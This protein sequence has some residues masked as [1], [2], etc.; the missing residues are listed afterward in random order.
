MSHAG[1]TTNRPFRVFNIIN[2]KTEKKYKLFL[3]ARRSSDESSDKQAQSIEDQ[4]SDLR[5]VAERQGIKIVEIL[6]ESKSSKR[7]Y[8]RPVFQSMLER[9]EAGEADGILCWHINRLSR[10]PIDSGQISWML[11]KGTI[12][13]IQT[14]ER[15]Y[16]PEDNVLLFSVESGMANQYIR[17]LAVASRRGMQG[18]ADRGWLP[19][20]A[21]LGY[22]N[23]LNNQIIIP[24]SERWDMVRKM[25]DL[26]LTGNYTVTQIQQIANNEWGFRTPKF[27]RSG[28]KVV[29]LSSLYR[30]FTNE[31]YTGTFV[32][33]GRQYSG[34]HE[35]MITNDEYDKVQVILGRNG[36]P[37]QQVH[38]SSY[39]GLVRC[40]EC[41]S[42]CTCTL[43]KKIVKKTGKL[44]T[45]VYYNCSK[46]KRDKYT[47]KAICSQKPITLK[48][49]EEQVDLDLERY[50]IIPKFQEWAL[51]VINRH[52]DTEIKERTAIYETQ[53][54][55]YN[56]T[57][58]QL[59]ML[60][61]MRYRLLIEEDEFLKERDDLKK[62][63]AKLKEKLETT[64]DRAKK[65]LELTEQTFNFAR[66]ARKEY[67]KGDIQKKRELFAAL[68]QNYVLKDKIVSIE[69]SEW[70]MPIEKAYP[71]L[72]A[73]FNR[74]ELDK[75]LSKSTYNEE[76]ASLILTWGGYRESNPGLKLHKLQ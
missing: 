26:I 5:P 57:Q 64:E 12:K 9:I 4:I 16:L 39:T 56:E 52:N 73:E 63:L 7:P 23:D 71:A 32:W 22:R 27:K 18:K 1:S 58:T 13:V 29:G 17:D 35:P 68:G 25:W 74:L 15:E 42:M 43:K 61:R 70:L 38:D 49:F 67:I 62:Q 41:G 51:D 20:R 3:Y 31:F 55:T 53:Q 54:K 66:H 2:M 30:I 36:K 37:R 14:M 72:E 65:W 8:I 75:H 40:G 69:A 24:D 60:T 19:S 47:G 10:N 46:K 21:P 6:E 44:E 34:N 76:I 45:Y 59:D 50:T 48:E 28:A 11:Q 33:A